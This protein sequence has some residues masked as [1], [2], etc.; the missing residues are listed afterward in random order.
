MAYLIVPT[1]GERF[2]VTGIDDVFDELN[3][4]GAEY[5]LERADVYGTFVTA[6]CTDTGY[7]WCANGA[8]CGYHLI[9]RVFDVARYDSAEI[10]YLMNRKDRNYE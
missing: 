10:E 3:T 4:L 2:T 1:E 7:R 8:E 6:R 5:G 9:G